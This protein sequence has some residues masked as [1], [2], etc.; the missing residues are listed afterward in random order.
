MTSL[1]IVAKIVAG[2]TPARSRYS[3]EYHG[4]KAAHVKMM[5]NFRSPTRLKF[6]HVRIALWRIGTTA[7]DCTAQYN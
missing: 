4:G 2:T 5:G 7:T 6:K 3:I 1:H